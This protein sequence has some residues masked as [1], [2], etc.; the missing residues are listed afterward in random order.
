MTRYPLLQ[1]F[2]ALTGFEFTAFFLVGLITIWVAGYIFDAIMREAAFGPLRNGLL[3]A[4]A[5]YLGLYLRIVYFYS[6]RQGEGEVTLASMVLAPCV[7]MLM[8]GLIKT[9]ISRG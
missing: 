7:F 1:Q 5:A 9:R 4:A 3:V 8:L 2:A 6:F